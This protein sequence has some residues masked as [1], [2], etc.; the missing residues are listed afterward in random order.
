VEHDM[1]RQGESTER[2]YLC[3][4]NEAELAGLKDEDSKTLSAEARQMKKS[5]GI[6]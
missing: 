5:Q 4:K 2:L 1:R 6:I 3:I